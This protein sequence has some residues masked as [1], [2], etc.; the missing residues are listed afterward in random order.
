MEQNKSST[1]EID[2]IFYFNR[3]KHYVLY[4]FRRLQRNRRLFLTIFFSI[5]LL[6]LAMRFIIPKKY[7]TE[8]LIISHNIPA[9]FVMINYLQ[10]LAS[11]KNAFLLSKELGIPIKSAKGVAQISAVRM[12]SIFR[13]S[14]SDQTGAIIKINL[15]IKNI[16]II[17][18][19][20]DGIV[21]YLKTNEYSVKQRLTRER[22]L[23]SLR[24]EL[25]RKNKSLDS[26]SGTESNSII[27][28]STENGL[29]LEKAVNPVNVNQLQL[30]Y[31][32]QQLEIENDLDMLKNIEVVQPFLTNEID[33]YPSYRWIF[34]YFVLAG[35][36]LA[37]VLTPLIGKK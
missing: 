2:L 14:Q 22:M 19:V 21:H 31:Y 10:S 26:L 37:F 8:A 36:L 20:Q 3:L 24:N 33:S 5:A 9:D 6:G 18:K 29:I 11:D 17:P 4:Y 34:A 13:F 1:E 25:I 28:R 15:A 23:E 7:F 30:E 16:D 12:D 27:S 32:K 35:L